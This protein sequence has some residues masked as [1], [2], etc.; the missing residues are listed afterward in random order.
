M[1]LLKRK[2]IPFDEEKQSMVSSTNVSG[3]VRGLV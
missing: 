3:M 1:I 2:T